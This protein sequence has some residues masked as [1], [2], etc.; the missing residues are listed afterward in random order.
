MTMILT[1]GGQTFETVEEYQRYQRQKAKEKMPDANV[2][3]RPARYVGDPSELPDLSRNRQADRRENGRAM[4]VVNFREAITAMLSQMADE[5]MAMQEALPNIPARQVNAFLAAMEAR[6]IEMSQL[7][8]RL[9]VLT[10]LEA[11]R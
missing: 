9:D 3:Q 4:N 2:L 11:E 1:D 8:A 6:A 7:A 10:S 5:H